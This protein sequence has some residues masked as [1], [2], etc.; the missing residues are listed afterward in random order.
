MIMDNVT[1]TDTDITATSIRM[2][3]DGLKA[4]DIIAWRNRSGSGQWLCYHRSPALMRARSTDARLDLVAL[5]CWQLYAIGKA[6]LVSRRVEDHYYEY[7][8]VSANLKPVK[9][10]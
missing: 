7:F 6:T 10:L 5:E 3:D 8:I 1:Q 9:R 4:G 2:T